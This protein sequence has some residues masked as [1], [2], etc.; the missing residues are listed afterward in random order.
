MPKKYF[1]L[2]K[3]F[4]T[5][6]GQLNLA[7]LLFF[8]GIMIFSLV[9][10]SSIQKTSPMMVLAVV[11]GLAVA[12]I[13]LVNTNFGLVILIFSMLWS[14]EIAVAG[15]VERPVTIRIDDFLIIT[16]FFTWL[17]KMAFTRQSGF[18]RQTPL[19]KPIFGFLIAN[20][21]STAL[22]IMAGNVNAKVSVFYILKFTEFFMVYFLFVNNI[23]H[24][25]QLK[26]F[27][28]CFLLTSFSIAIFASSQIGQVDRPTTPFEGEH[29]EPNT[30]G[31]Y[32]M[33]TMAVAAGLFLYS[34]FSISKV[35]LG[36][37]FC[38]SFYPLLMTLSRSSYLG[39]VVAILFLVLTTR[40]GRVFLVSALM[41]SIL[42]L[43]LVTPKVVQERIVDTFRAKTTIDIAGEK[44]GLEASAYARV[45][46]FQH[47]VK[48]LPKKPIFGYGVLGAGFIDP[49]FMRYLGE[50]G[51]F[52]FFMFMWL[53]ISIIVNSWKMFNSI[54]DVFLNGLILGM[55]AGLIGLLVMANGAAVFGIIRIAEPFWFVVACVISIPEI[56][57]TTPDETDNPLSIGGY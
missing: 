56:Y 45:Q 52:G 6:P 33:F 24:I 26:I 44:V 9:I 40:K 50:I 46:S 11:A 3:I 41:F 36:G 31:G 12:I 7:P 47:I 29:Y 51:L 53:I 2:E 35:L 25:K 16:V 1:S 20:M 28:L 37:L 27:I 17:A 42:F 14:P 18:I 19:N 8:V 15:T 10:A 34:K 55:L 21:I 54:D 13:T 38:F 49:Q 32:L 48:I 5:N 43:P 57:P 23:S 22:G 30:L 4:Y 39:L